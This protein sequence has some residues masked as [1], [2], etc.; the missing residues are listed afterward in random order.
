MDPHDPQIIWV[1]TDKNGH[2]Y[3]S[4]DGGHTWEEKD[5]G[6]TIEYDWLSFRGFTVDPRSS[7][8]VYAMGEVQYG[9]NNVWGD[10]V[11]GV[12]YK[13]VDGGDHWELI[14]DGGIPSSLARYMWIDPRDPDV[15]LLVGHRCASP[16]ELGAVEEHP[17]Q[18]QEHRG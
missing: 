11:G 7:D 8:I 6:V 10:R 3:K 2:I 1:G 17:V 15:V 12:V 9:G 4:T 5:E 16:Q 18:G 13:T 14:W